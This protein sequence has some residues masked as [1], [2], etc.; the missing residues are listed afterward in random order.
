MTETLDPLSL[1]QR[2]RAVRAETLR[3]TA[4]LSPEDCQVQSM[5][6]TSPAKWHLAHTTWFF[7]TFVLE[8]F[9]PGFQPVD[10][11]FRTLYNSYYQAVGPQHPRPQRGLL[12]RPDLATVQAYRRAVDERVLAQAERLADPETATLLTLGLHHEQQ[13][14]E[15][16]VT[17]AKHLLWHNPLGTGY[18]PGEP[19]PVPAAAPAVWCGFD[20]GLVG[21][22][23]DPTQDGSFH[24]DNEGPRHRVFV[25]PF[26]L[27]DRLVSQGE[28]ADFIA[29]GGYRQV[30]LWTSL[31]WDWVQAGRREA[32]L[33]WHRD[34]PDAPW[35]VYTLFGHRPLERDTPALHL[36]WYEA[37]AI[38]RWAGARLPTEAEWETG[39]RSGRLQQVRD[40]AWQWTGSAYRPYPGYRVPDGAVGEY[41]GKF[42]AQQFVLRGGSLATP[43]GHARLSYRNFFPPE[44]QWQFSGLRLARDA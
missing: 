23:H 15:L 25:E 30:A 1:L 4:M 41:N 32:P 20:G 28:V 36:S 17:D 33:Y 10:R 21:I 34:A 9:E 13:H 27:R 39:A 43:D 31:G 14:Q 19:P 35:Q 8:R 42:M 16:I 3:R 12:T 40:T 38:A 5:P 22:G 18:A 26:E 37:E 7:E 11:A 6:D 2:Y 29:D 24:F 44:A